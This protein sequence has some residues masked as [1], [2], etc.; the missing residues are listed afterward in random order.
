M[1]MERFC[2]NCG[3]PR[4]AGSRF[5]VDCGSPFSDSVEAMQI[6]PPSEPPVAPADWYQGLDG[7]LWFWDG[8][9]YTHRSWRGLIEPVTGVAANAPPAS[10]GSNASYGTAGTQNTEAMPPGLGAR[11]RIQ[12]I[13]YGPDFDAEK[14]CPNCGFPLAEDGHCESCEPQ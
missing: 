3:H 6:V 11:H 14:D 12:E 1:T 10:P 2:G 4:E 9:R 5:C 13:E 7:K 8:D